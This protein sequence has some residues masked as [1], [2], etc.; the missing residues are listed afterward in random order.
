MCCMIV[1]SFKK[2]GVVFMYVFEI[3]ERVLL[4]GSEV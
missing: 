4:N 1:V 3:G 2:F